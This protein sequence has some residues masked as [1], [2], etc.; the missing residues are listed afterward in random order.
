MAPPK[1]KVNKLYRFLGIL[2]AFLVG[3]SGYESLKNYQEDIKFDELYLL[4][5]L[6]RQYELTNGAME[7]YVK[8][9]LEKEEHIR[10]IEYFREANYQFNTALGIASTDYLEK[11][12]EQF[13]SIFSQYWQ[14]ARNL[15]EDMDTTLLELRLQELQDIYNEI[16]GNQKPVL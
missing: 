16:D 6:I 3:L 5:T 10:T 13:T 11:H 7:L 1:K 14:E 8:G 4:S 12:E 9:D 2:A 15:P